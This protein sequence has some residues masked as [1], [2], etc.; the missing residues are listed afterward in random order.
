MSFY[1]QQLEAW[2]KTLAIKGN[3]VLDIGGAQG[4]VKDRVMLWDVKNYEVMDLPEWDLNLDW[5]DQAE[6]KAET[7]DIIFCLEV[8]EYLYNPMVALRNIADL[9]RPG[10]SAY[11]TFQFVYPHHNELEFDTLRYT[12]PGLTRMAQMAGLRVKSTWYRVDDSGYL[13]MF[14]DAD[15]MRKAKQYQHH[16]ATGFIVEFTK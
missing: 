9:L 6:E 1:R 8:F 5:N 2:L 16:N 10:G 14:Y 13:E 15:G 4:H 3:T 7:A 11:V 12:E